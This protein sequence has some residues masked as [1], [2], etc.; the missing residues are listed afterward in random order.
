MNLNRRGLSGTLIILAI[1]SMS[2]SDSTLKFWSSFVIPSWISSSANLRP[3]HIRGPWPKGRMA[4][5]WMLCLSSIHLS[6]MNWSVGYLNRISA[7]FMS[8]NVDSASRKI[9]VDNIWCKNID[10]FLREPLQQQLIIA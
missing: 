5:G 6:G 3:M 1:G 4:N 2:S 9:L 8:R 10:T 7:S